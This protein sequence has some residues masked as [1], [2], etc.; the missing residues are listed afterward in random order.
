MTCFKPTCGRAL[1]RG[2]LAVLV[3][4]LWSLGANAQTIWAWGSNSYGQL[5]DGTTISR[6]FPVR[7]NGLCSV[8]AIA[9]GYDHSLAILD[10]GSLWGWGYNLWGQ[11]GD[12]TFT[13]RYSPVPVSGL[14]GAVALG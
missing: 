14:S 11:V 13:D 8:V 4:A 9:G 12:G 5:G 3:L 7:V 10:D 6:S 1:L 2:C